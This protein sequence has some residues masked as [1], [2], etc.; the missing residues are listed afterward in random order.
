MVNYS[1]PYLTAVSFLFGVASLAVL[2]RALISWFPIPKDNQLVRLLNMI[3]EPILAPIRKLIENSS[4][5]KNIMVD[6][7]PIIAL[8]LLEVLKNI[9]IMILRPF[10]L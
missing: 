2:A 3:T 7:S 4:F 8:L 1:N 6:I 10:V 5:G 9:I